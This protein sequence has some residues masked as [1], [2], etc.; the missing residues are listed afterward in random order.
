VPLPFLDTNIFLRHL[1]QDEPNH[2]PRATAYLARIQAGQTQGCIAETVVFEIVFILE[3]THKQGKSAISDS[4]LPLIELPG[5]VV[6]NKRRF[7]EIFDLYVRLNISIVDAYHAV[8]MCRLGLDE[9][10]SFDRGFDRIAGIRR[11]EP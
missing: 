10:V 5:L 2:S 7:R 4:V 9:I 8:T 6:P 3:R 11:I 1:L